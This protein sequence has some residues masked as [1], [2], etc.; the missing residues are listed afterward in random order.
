MT[1]RS[2][3]IVDERDIDVIEAEFVNIEQSSVRAVEAGHA[4]MQQVAA[5]SIDGDRIEVTQGAA[6]ILKGNEVSLNQSIT[7]V[8]AGNSTA[9]NFS[10]SP[11]VVSRNEGVLNKS[12]VGIMVA[13]NLKSENS[14]SLL[15]IANKVDGKV[16]TLLDLRGAV[17]IGAVFGGLW[18]LFSLL[19][20][21]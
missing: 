12:A 20:K 9:L 7:A 14:T 2:K 1:P 6:V 16:T 17:A 18:G 3:D 19:R 13:A 4:A 10:F 15:M 21:R 8:T 11:M 5:L